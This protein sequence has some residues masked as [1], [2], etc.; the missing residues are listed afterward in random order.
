M[1]PWAAI[2]ARPTLNSTRSGSNFTPQAPAAARIRPT[3]GSHP[4]SAVL[5]RGELAIRRATL[6]AS[7][8]ERAPLTRTIANF[9]A[10]S[11][12]SAICRARSLAIAETACSNFS[13]S[14]RL[15]KAELAARPL[16][17]SKTASLVD[18]SPSTVSALKLVGSAFLSA[19]RRSPDDALASVTI[20]ASIVAIAGAI[21]PAPLAI[22]IRVTSRPPSASVV[23]LTLGRVSVVIVACAV[24]TQFGAGDFEPLLQTAKIVESPDH[25]GRARDY[26]MRRTSEKLCE[27]VAR[28]YSEFFS[29][30]PG[31]AIGRARVD[32]HGSSF[33]CP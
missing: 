11:P 28:R 14:R 22:P 19:W 7:A 5:T 4:K 10:P 8:R 20:K 18:M 2:R 21:I 25:A 26:E 24:R 31:E 6:S 33:A 17:S 30:A 16:A 3:F 29:R 1:R 27:G 12:S 15:L 13:T 9:V 23:Q 32:E